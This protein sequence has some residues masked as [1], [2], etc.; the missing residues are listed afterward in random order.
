M[1]TLELTPDQVLSLLNQ[2]TPEAKRAAIVAL[3][4]AAAKGRETR[5]QFAEEQLRRL[6]ASRSKNW[7]GMPDAE[8]EAFLDEVL[9]EDKACR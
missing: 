5:M 6:A 8:R 9:H 2:L 7:D 1:P 4:G 3:A